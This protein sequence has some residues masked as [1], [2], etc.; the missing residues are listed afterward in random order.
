MNAID[1]WGCTHAFENVLA[2]G[3]N[4]QLDRGHHRRH[5]F[6]A[7]HAVSGDAST[8]E[9]GGASST[10]D[11]ATASTHKDAALPRPGQLCSP[12]PPA[13]VYPWCCCMQGGRD[14]RPQAPS[15]PFHGGPVDYASQKTWDRCHPQTVSEILVVPSGL[16]IVP[17]RYKNFVGGACPK[18]C[19]VQGSTSESSSCSFRA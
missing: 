19:V 14:S 4:G 2:F 6:Q 13:Q 12:L 3:W 17:H 18:F 11:E 15:S 7:M 10:D 16:L 5:L 9:P 1:K 8:D